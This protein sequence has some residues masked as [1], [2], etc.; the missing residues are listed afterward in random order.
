MN[1]TYIKR[2]L[3]FAAMAAAIFAA[4]FGCQS[5]ADA[6]PNPKDYFKPDIQYVDGT[7]T[8]NGPARGYAAGG[9]TV[10]KP[11]GL[12]KWKGAKAYNSSLWELSK[13]SGGRV[14][15][16][17]SVPTNRVGGADIPLTD[18]MKADVRRYLEETRQ[19]GGSLIVRLGYTWSDS[20]GCEPSD[21]EVVLGH[22][23]DL[24]KIMADYTT[25]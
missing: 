17:H 4:Q 15:G 1:T 5:Q 24:S 6:A 14:Q 2:A 9:W 10:F 22:V 25:M 23:R 8:F 7:N 21:F 16:K 19:N 20:Q 13:F 11:E 12:P 18:V 3:A